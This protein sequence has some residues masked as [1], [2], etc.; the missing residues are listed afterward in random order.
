MKL[1]VR[2]NKQTYRVELPE[3]DATVT[4]LSV[5]I[6]EVL[7]PSQGLSP[8]TEIS[9]SLN[10]KEPLSDTG[11]TLA[12]AS[13][14]SGDLI[15]VILPQ[16]SAV[17]ADPAP[18]SVTTESP[19]C[20]GSQPAPRRQQE[21]ECAALCH[22]N[23][24]GPTS[25]A[26]TSQSA[27]RTDGT[28]DTAGVEAGAGLGTGPCTQ[29]PML[30]NEAEDGQAPLSL[31]LLHLGA[32]STGPCDS[33]AVAVHLLMLETGFMPQDRALKPGD[34]PSGWRSPGGAYKLQYNHPWCENSLIMVIGL[35]MGPVLV[36]NATLKVNEKVDAVRKLCLNPSSYVADGST[37]AAAAAVFKDLAKLSR[38]F[39]D[40]L[41]YP[42]IAAARA[43]MAL[44]PVFGLCVLPPELLLRVLRQLDASSLVALSAVNSRL[45][46]AAADSTLWRHLYVRD[47]RGQDPSTTTETDWKEL[48]KRKYQTRKHYQ[49]TPHHWLPP[50]VHP[51]VPGSNPFHP[52]PFLPYPPG[53]IGGDYD[54]TPHF[55][56]GVLPRPRHDPLGPFP[57]GP[58]VIGPS[59][60][61]GGPGPFSG[62]GRARDIRRGFI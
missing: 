50:P 12:S 60:R 29:E 53:I 27:D 4:E 58:P 47:F 33:I 31:E 39:K 38:I 48:Y 49:Q 10:G 18:R 7:L 1:R 42:L 30:C 34:M 44:P 56:L 35:S 55:P 9:L 25:T 23:R 57:G 16:S 45:R 62:G 19:S 5:Q 37:E 46:S 51:L 22:E 36:I 15:C 54:Q 28:M 26:T 43:A 2:I 11:Q 6:K 20:S 13:I 8:D 21:A 24:P 17:A 14:V 32:R 40:Q 59:R 61:R 3:G 41:A 52:Q